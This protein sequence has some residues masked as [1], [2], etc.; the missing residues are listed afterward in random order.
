MFKLIGR[1]FVSIL[2]VTFGYLA[3]YFGW[4]NQL[5]DLI[6]SCFVR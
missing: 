1:I 5:F 2:F 4:F 3:C 6:R